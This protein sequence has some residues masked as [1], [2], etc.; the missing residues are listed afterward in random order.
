MNYF[1]VLMKIFYGTVDGRGKCG[2]DDGDL[3]YD[4]DEDEDD[5][6]NVSEQSMNIC[7]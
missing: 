1:M 5:N 6:N 3:D 2:D 4:D 7:F